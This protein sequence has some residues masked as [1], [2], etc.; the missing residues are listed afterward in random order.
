MSVCTED[1][2]GREKASANNVQNNT[3]AEVSSVKSSA[4]DTFCT[5][6]GL[7]PKQTAA[8][9]L[10]QIS[11]PNAMG[12]VLAKVR[13]ARSLTLESVSRQT[14]ISIDRLQALESGQ[15]LSLAPTYTKGYLK[16]YANFLGIDCAFLSNSSDVS[17]SKNDVQSAESES[18]ISVNQN[19][20]FAPAGNFRMG[21]SWARGGLSSPL[22]LLRAATSAA[23]PLLMLCVLA[24]AYNAIDTESKVA[25]E[26]AS[27][28][29]LEAQNRELDQFGTLAHEAVGSPA[30]VTTPAVGTTMTAGQM[31]E[32]LAKSIQPED[33]QT[34][35]SELQGENIQADISSAITTPSIASTALANL[36]IPENL[37]VDTGLPGVSTYESASKRIIAPSLADTSYIREPEVDT[38]TLLEEAAGDIIMVGQ[39]NSMGVSRATIPNAGIEDSYE[40]IGP[41][42]VEMIAQ[43][44]MQDRLVI[45]VYEDSW[46]DVTD[47]YGVRLYRDLAKAGRRID[48]SGN[49]PFSLHVGNAPG[50]EL[51]LNGEPVEITRYRS[52]NS[53]R[54]TLA[55]N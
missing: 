39:F 21:S 44:Q 15:K 2:V 25:N 19:N 14:N 36:Q 13:H 41:R 11:T 7:D 45:T 40:P 6:E 3:V 12:K 47:S 32:A 53:A 18:H 38:G 35:I 48:V 50:L 46:V 10:H 49:L 33:E 23:L 4:S 9:N 31:S 16:V 26:N 37:D 1:P 42:A 43:V 34:S 22:G 17:G 51:Q 28:A 29:A 5:I 52:D 30:V 20:R 54:L 55:S 8:L 24:F 27:I